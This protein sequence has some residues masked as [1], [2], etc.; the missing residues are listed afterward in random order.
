MLGKYWG[1]RV[2]LLDLEEGK[3]YRYDFPD[4]KGEKQVPI[5]NFRSYI[6]AYDN[7]VPV[8]V[9]IKDITVK[10]NEPVFLP[11][12]LLEGTTGP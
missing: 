11:I 2:D 4:G 1:A 3:R 10:E 6:Y 12:T 9:Q 8:M 7:G 5:G